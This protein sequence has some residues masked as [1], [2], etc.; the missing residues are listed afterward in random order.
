MYSLH[1]RFQHKQASQVESLVSPG[2][3]MLAQESQF[4]LSVGT[5]MQ[6][7]LVLYIR[8]FMWR[9]YLQEI[10]YMNSIKHFT[11]AKETLANINQEVQNCSC[12]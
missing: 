3:N 4:I 1:N 5:D 12:F 2:P 6:K 11:K 10:S 8:N 9:I 7:F